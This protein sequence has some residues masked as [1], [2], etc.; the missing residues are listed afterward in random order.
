[1]RAVTIQVAV[2]QGRFDHSHISP[3]RQDD[4]LHFGQDKAG[5]I[6]RKLQFKYTCISIKDKPLEIDK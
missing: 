1:M 5:G 6:Q 4:D 3:A 2:W